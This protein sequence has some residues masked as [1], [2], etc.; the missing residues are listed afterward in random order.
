LQAN[1]FK[2]VSLGFQSGKIGLSRV[3]KY[4]TV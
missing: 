2:K 3:K 1:A 4:I